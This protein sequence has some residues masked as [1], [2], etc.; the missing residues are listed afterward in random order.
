MNWIDYWSQDDFWKNSQLWK[1][2][3]RLFYK[4]AKRFIEFEKT[5]SVLDIGCGAG[6]TETLLAPLVR[7]VYAV[8]VAKQF[9]DIC[10]QRCQ[11]H[12]NVQVRYLSKEDYTNLEKY[13]GPFSIILCVSVVQ[14]YRNLSEVES[15]I[16]S[17]KKLASGGAQMLIADLPRQ[18]GKAGFIWD[19]LCSCFLSIRK[20]YF[21]T[22][23]PMAYA[24]WLH[25]TRYKSFCEQTQQL[26]FS[27]DMLKSLIKKLQINARIIQ[28]DFSVYANRLSL[29]I[30][31]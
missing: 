9:V 12:S 29:L 26:Y 7:S 11:G 27:E 17:I 2:N 18:R 23:L 8:D 31:F 30:Q 21:T 4:S 13:P 10:S 20:G 19:V 14:Y 28:G 6:Y 24:R 5:D 22:L 16:N 1:I 15:L 25:N 3:S